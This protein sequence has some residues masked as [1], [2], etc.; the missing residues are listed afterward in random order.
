MEW[1]ILI[2]LLIL[3]ITLIVVEIIFIPG[4]TIVGILG[5][6]CLIS[7][8]FTAFHQFGSKTGNIVLLSSGVFLII[9]IIY[10]FKAKTWEKMALNKIIDSKVNVLDS[11]LLKVGCIAVAVSDIKPIGVIEFENE[12]FEAESEGEYISTKSSVEIIQ[13]NNNQIIVKQIK[14]I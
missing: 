12:Q 7:G 6:I 11:D 2:A 1:G 9:S 10:I 14:E 8:I 3:G 13:I 4:T 5:F